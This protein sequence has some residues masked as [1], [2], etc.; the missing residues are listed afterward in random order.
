[1]LA[2]LAAAGCGS[3][4]PNGDLPKTVPVTGKV[5]FKNAQPPYAGLVQFRSEGGA[6][7]TTMGEIQSDGSF[8]LITVVG[9]TK[10]QGA[11]EGAYSVTV[12]P[13]VGKSYAKAVHWQNKV[14][15]RAA[16]ENQ[17]AITVALTN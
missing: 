13:L 17:V 12:L 5:V 8:S 1:M 10:L 14:N 7:H 2:A 3:N 16:G 11:A 6:G 9:R 15:V 4:D